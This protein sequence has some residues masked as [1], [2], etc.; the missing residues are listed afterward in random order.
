MT[1]QFTWLFHVQ[2]PQRQALNRLFCVS[3]EIRLEELMTVSK[4]DQIQT[5]KIPIWS[6]W[7]R[8]QGVVLLTPALALLPPVL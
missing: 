4:E 2:Q 7:L 5:P 3:I 1:R 8:D 6:A